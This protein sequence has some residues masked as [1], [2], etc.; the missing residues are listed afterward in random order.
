M[1]RDRREARANRRALTE[2]R[3]GPKVSAIY[4]ARLWVA[5]CRAIEAAWD[6]PCSNALPC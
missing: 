5:E 3:K 6:M 2:L 4:R 1:L